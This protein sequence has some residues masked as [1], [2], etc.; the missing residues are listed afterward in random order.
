MN[1]KANAVFAIFIAAFLVIFGVATAV[2][3]IIR[4]GIDGIVEAGVCIIACAVICVILW[5]VFKGA[6]NK[7]SA[8]SRSV[9]KTVAEEEISG[10]K[11]L[12]WA[13]CVLAI[14][15]VGALAL[16]GGGIYL[17]VHMHGDK[18]AQTLAE[19][20]KV[21]GEIFYRYNV[22]GESVVSA[23]GTGWT[24]VYAI[25]GRTVTLFYKIAEP[26]SVETYSTATALFM[27][28]IFF[29]CIALLAFCSYGNKPK[30]L[31][32]IGCVGFL[33][34]GVGLTVAVQ[35][36]FGFTFWELM[37]SGVSVF[38]VNILT[39]FG[40]YFAVNIIVASIKK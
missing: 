4:Y 3:S 10:E 8:A 24:G 29:L 23:G 16:F 33:D 26:E 22:A 15:L 27:G 37:T 11:S 40:I 30:F 1:K 19:V 18:F 5:K 6:F 34:F 38:L 21:D 9:K 2:L 32:I 28:G 7:Q 39:V 12:K 36:A 25:E 35:L 14:G 17:I 20:T 13:F 31:P